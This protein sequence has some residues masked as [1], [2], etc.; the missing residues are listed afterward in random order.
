MIAAIGVD[1]D[2]HNTAIAV[3]TKDQVLALGVVRGQKGLIEDEAVED[4]VYRFASPSIDGGLADF[5]WSKG[6]D[7]R[8]PGLDLEIKGCRVEGQKRYLGGPSLPEDLIRLATV[9]GGA[10]AHLAQWS[11]KLVQ[12]SAWKGSVDKTTNQARTLAAY[13]I[14]YKVVGGLKGYCIPAKGKEKLPAIWTSDG[15]PPL[16]SD[17]KHVLD[18]VGIARW[19]ALGARPK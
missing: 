9:A 15:S 16:Q 7:R 10:M 4:M 3:A 12:P 2:L 11:P 1:P 5:V 18:A 19:A 17:W 14:S 8:R 13:G 6:F